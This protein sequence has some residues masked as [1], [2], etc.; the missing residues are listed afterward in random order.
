MGEQVPL[1]DWTWRMSWQWRPD[2]KAGA[3]PDE[4]TLD[5]DDWSCR[6]ERREERDDG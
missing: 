4:I 5:S 1:N 6:Y 2:T 3:P